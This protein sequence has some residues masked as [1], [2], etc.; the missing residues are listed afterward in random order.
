[1]KTGRERERW[2]GKGEGEE[3][4]GEKECTMETHKAAGGQRQ[5]NR[6]TEPERQTETGIKKVGRQCQDRQGQTGRG[7]DRLGD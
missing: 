2:E 6:E 3:R 4:L 1:M 5:I 7:V